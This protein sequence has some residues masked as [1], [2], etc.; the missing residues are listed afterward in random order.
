MKK[1]QYRIFNDILNVLSDQDEFDINVYN[2]E[3]LLIA[4]VISL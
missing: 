2:F 3:K 4:I 1:W